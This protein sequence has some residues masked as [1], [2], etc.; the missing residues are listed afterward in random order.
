MHFWPSMT[1]HT[2]GINVVAPVKWRCLDGLMGAFWEA[3]C[4][5]GARGYYLADDPRIM[6]FFNDVSDSVRISNQ[7]GDF[8]QQYRPMTRAIFIPA[9]VPMWTNIG[10]TH[11]VTHLNLHMHKDRLLRFLAPSLGRSAALAALRSP[12]EIEDV[13]AIE[14]LAKLLVDEISQPSR[15]AI[16]AE[17]LANSI[18]ASLLDIPAERNET[19]EGRLTQGQMNKLMVRLNT[20]GNGRLSVAEMAGA[21]GLSE[22]WFS[23]V[24]KQTTGK[25]P[26]Q[27]QLEKRIELA[28]KLLMESDLSVA[29]IA[30]QLDFSDQAHLTKVF[31]HVAGGT[32]AAWRR[33]Q[34]R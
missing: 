26:L 13:E 27:W 22:S 23:T 30:A 11:R 14:A 29:N 8:S 15:P 4:Q 10:A 7:S 6:I 32:P 3:D 24:F 17:S 1:W 2:E 21:V 9:G 25:T 28:K 33:L 16:Y 19:S 18:V 12:V 5:S 20:R 31:R 34:A